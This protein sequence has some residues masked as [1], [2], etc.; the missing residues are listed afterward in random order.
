MADIKLCTYNARGLR[1][2]R[3]R[4]QVFAFLHKQNKDIYFIQETHS[5]LSDERY[6]RSEWG[7]CIVFCHGSSTSRGVCILFNPRLD[8]NIHSTVVGDNGRALFMEITVMQKRFMF[9]CLYGPNID[10]PDFYD[11]LFRKVSDSELD[12]LFELLP[13]V[14]SSVK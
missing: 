9:V 11:S 1:Q 7:G 8:F 13:L 4:R 14:S 3:K 5:V 10:D 12:S 2:N 6:W